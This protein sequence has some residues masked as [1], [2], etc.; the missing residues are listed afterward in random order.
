M[1]L[2]RLEIQQLPGI[3]PGFVFEGLDPGV[4]LVTGPNGVGKT[5]LIRAFRFLIAGVQPNDPPALSLT[6][7]FESDDKRWVVRRTGRDIVW[8]KDG[9]LAEAPP[10]PDP[11]EL[12]CYLLEMELL[13]KAEEAD[14]R[15]SSEVRR[16][17]RGGYDL[18]ALKSLSLF[19]LKK[20]QGRKEAERL[21]EARKKLRKVEAEREQLR[22]DEGRIPKLEDEIDAAKLA[23]E[24]RDELAQAIALYEAQQKRHNI[25][26]GLATYPP[27]MERLNGHEL[28]WLQELTDKRARLEEDLKAQQEQ[29][30][31]A[32]QKLSDTGLADR[33]PNRVELDTPQSKLQ[34]AK[35][36]QVELNARIGDR[37]KAQ[38]QLE[39]ALERLGARPEKLP[40]LSPKDTSEAEKLARE[41]YKAEHRKAELEA[42][43]DEQTERPD[44]EEIERLFRAAEAL[45]EWLAA[46]GTVPRRLRWAIVLATVGV[47]LA[48]IGSLWSGAWSALLGS[49]IATAGLIWAW[50][51]YR[52]GGSLA[53]QRR[54]EQAGVEPPQHWNTVSVRE[55]LQ[56]IED[57]RRRLD[58]KRARAERAAKTRR[59]LEQLEQQLDELHRDKES[60]AERIGFDPQLAAS[61]LAEFLN[62]VKEF[63]TAK[64]EREEA[65]EQI[66]LIKQAIKEVADEAFNFLTNWGEQPADRSIEALD[67]ALQSLSRRVAKAEEAKIGLGQ[68]EQQQKRIQSELDELD[69]QVQ[70]LYE[71]AGVPVGDSAELRHRYELLESW[72]EQQR[73]LTEAKAVE[74]ERKRPIETET[75]LL[76]RVEAG[77]EQWL[78]EELEKAKEQAERLE[79]LKDERQ[80]IKNKLERAGRDCALEQ[81]AAAV[82]QARDQL[83]DALDRTLFA[84]AARFLLDAVENE[85]RGEHVPEVLREARE[86]FKRFTHHRYN[87]IVDLDTDD[88][89][90]GL[91]AI[92]ADTRQR[93]SL[94]EL[95][96]GTRMQLLLA[97]RMAWLRR[98]ERR[99]EPL[100]VFLDE[101]LTTADED[102]F[103]IVARTIEQW[104]EDEGRQF[105]YLSARRHEVAL[106]ERST[107]RKP[108]HIDLARLRF[109]TAELEPDFFKLPEEGPL[110]EPGT[111]SP[112]EYAALLGVPPLDPRAGAGSL[113][114]FYLLRDELHTLHRLME[115]WRIGTLGQLEL[116]LSSEAA[117]KAIPDPDYRRRLA[118]RCRAART[119]FDVWRRGRG[120][121]VDRVA[122]EQSGAVSNSFIDEV[123][124]LAAQLGGDARALIAKLR[125]G[126]VR[127]FR[128]DK[129]DQLE[130]W[131]R[132]NGYLDEAEPL[133]RLA[134][135]RQTLLEAGSDQY[136]DQ[137]RLVLRWFEAAWSRRTAETEAE[138]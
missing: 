72:Q 109:K 49:A 125:D 79:S 15:F 45:R 52:E 38:G 9:R 21:V 128:S 1:R 64:R 88:D 96:T 46:E 99:S 82:E 53:A 93:R 115:E 30:R 56:N 51:L 69:K 60:L 31:L 95:S 19:G 74:A 129:T 23:A 78:N 118:S 89:G 112:E 42:R 34:H 80:D 8:E 104:A 26:A 138:R 85:Y 58:E 3:E 27:G 136:H 71:Q 13:V 73:K 7:E 20:N 55:R 87:L 17:L 101:A 68:A 133:D 127:R 48:T 2:V 22:R 65:E 86:H 4:N 75:E 62:L 57:K 90:S 97:V 134:R 32:K 94:Q 5:S 84:E 16:Q 111:R 18:D 29:Q 110:P 126:T 54:F 100:P 98:L 36:R 47:T 66:K 108:H 102:R 81:A 28:E 76:Q 130:Q 92:E 113:H 83:E 116:L 40:Q 117:S 41:L 103:G 106:W 114:L 107:G 11:D 6:A 25:E 120:K 91:V 10:L 59:E 70:A 123:T 14:E 105:F 124:E 35:T 43:L 61:G 67:V 33:F 121:P 77:D 44:P 12:T 135:E 131:L 122:L 63:H 137:I 132:G 24:R 119:W 50:L 39:T 37:A